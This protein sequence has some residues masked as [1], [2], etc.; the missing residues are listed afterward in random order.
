MARTFKR[1]G[2]EGQ[3][4]FEGNDFAAFEFAGE[5]GADA[6]LAEFGGASPAGAEFAVL[7]HADLHAGVEGKAR[8]TASMG[9]GRRG[10][11]GG[12][13]FFA[14]SCHKVSGQWSVVSGKQ[15]NRPVSDSHCCS[16]PRSLATDH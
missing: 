7:K 16:G 10:R 3:R 14:R 2:T 13:E 1:I 11:L 8:K 5:G 15:V 9:S 6:V 12:C 4:N